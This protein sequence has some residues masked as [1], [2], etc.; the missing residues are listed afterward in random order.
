MVAAVAGKNK[1]PPLP[2]MPYLNTL[3]RSNICLQNSWLGARETVWVWVWRL[4][5]WETFRT[6]GAK[7]RGK[8][9]TVSGWVVVLCVDTWYWYRYRRILAFIHSYSILSPCYLTHDSESWNSESL[10]P[11]IDH[12]QIM[13][14]YY[15]ELSWYCYLLLTTHLL[16]HCSLSKLNL[17]L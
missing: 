7:T 16:Y 4:G 14:W 6:N 10:T 15:H 11:N 5:K 8:L 12:H 1:F 13:I 2:T 3:P 17:K 9:E